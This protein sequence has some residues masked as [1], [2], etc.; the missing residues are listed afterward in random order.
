VRGRGRGV[1]RERE[2]EVETKV[3]ATRCRDI[4][5][6]CEAAGMVATRARWRVGSCLVSKSGVS[7]NSGWGRDDDVGTGDKSRDVWEG[8]GDRGY[9]DG[10]TV[11][12]VGAGAGAGA[13]GVGGMRGTPWEDKALRTASQPRSKVF[14]RSLSSSFSRSRSCCRR[15]SSSG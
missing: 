4:A 9:D 8:A 15:R 7:F 13:G 3:E 10:G 12:D 1:G 5:G 14:I 2:T 6:G 11:V